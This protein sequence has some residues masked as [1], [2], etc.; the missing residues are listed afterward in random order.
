VKTRGFF[1]VAVVLTVSIVLYTV[2]L[3]RY[4]WLPSYLKVAWATTRNIV[5]NAVTLGHYVSLEGRVRGGVF[6]NW[7]G[8]FRYRPQRIV[9][10]TTE[11]EI[12][13]LVKGSQRLRVF[14]SGHS[15]NAAVVSEETLVSLD[16]YSGLI[17]KYPDKNQIVVKAGTRVR[18]V[19]RLLSDEG[20]AF[21]ALPS[22]DAQSMAGILSTDVHGTGK[23]FGTE[24]Q[25]WG[26]VS[27]SVARLSLI[28]GKGEKHE[29]FPSDDLFKAAIG[30]I[31]AVGIITEVV[32]QG[33]PRFN[34]EQK[35]EMLPMCDVET[36]LERLLDVN[37]HLSLYLFPFMDVCQVNTWNRKEKVPTIVGRLLE[38]IELS[39][40]RLVEFMRISMDA[41]AAAWL[42]GFVAYTG[43]LPQSGRTY[44]GLKKGSDLLL[45]SNKGFNRT[46][47]HLH[48]E[49]EFTVPFKDTFEV[50]KSFLDL[51]Q[52]LYKRVYWEGTHPFG[53][54]YALFEVRFTPE[55][56]L[57][58]IGA[59]R[60]R[61]STWIDLVCNDSRGY[62]RFYAEAEKRIK[63]IG[64]RPHLGKHCESLDRGDLERLHGN[65]F[66]RFL[67]LKEKHDPHEKFAN[68]F[69]RRLFGH[70]VQS[71]RT[72]EEVP[73]AT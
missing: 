42:G 53:L 58:L 11:K 6:R 10:P 57:T 20:L 31:G 24:D 30:G 38:S 36:N 25:L 7:A 2:A 26:F 66:T 14:G 62:E 23:I 51:Y 40:G 54:P 60:G 65:D 64:A 8:R 72:R 44:G 52:H 4:V 67:E 9:R 45:E 69:T 19:V 28:D 35:V 50:C 15:F 34:I 1:K 49:L 61:R 27:Q 63:K 16:D 41:L 48:Q 33:V 59:G 73:R 71:R 55:H 39:R 21:R 32:V 68:D 46:I 37:D 12:V 13:E 18:D 3:K 22:H 47:Y 43:G 17:C 29:C 70:R 5:L 56:D